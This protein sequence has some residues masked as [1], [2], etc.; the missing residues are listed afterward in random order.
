[1][2]KI[3][4]PHNSVMHI[5]Q[6]DL[7]GTCDRFRQGSIVCIPHRRALRS[8]PVFGMAELPGIGEAGRFKLGAGQLLIRDHS[9]IDVECCTRFGLVNLK[10][11]TADDRV[12]HSCLRKDPG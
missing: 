2:Q 1:M 10:R 9:H 12:R 4:A 8:Y 7:S 5:L 6:L 11:D 3:D